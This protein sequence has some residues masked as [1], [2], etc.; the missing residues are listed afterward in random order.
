[1]S[2]ERPTDK[3]RAGTAVGV[4]DD[5]GTVVTGFMEAVKEWGKGLPGAIGDAS[6][7]AA[8]HLPVVKYSVEGTEFAIDTAQRGT[9]GGVV[10]TS[11]IAGGAAGAAAGAKVGAGFGSFLGPH[12]TFFG[13]VIGL[14]GGAAGGE[15]AA[16]A[17]AEWAYDQPRRAPPGYRP[18][19]P[20]RD[21]YH[22]VERGFISLR[23]YAEM[24]RDG[25]QWKFVRH[26]NRV[27]TGQN[28]HHPD[29][30]ETFDEKKYPIKW[31]GSQ[32]R[33]RQSQP[34]RPK[35]GPASP[36][37]RP[38]DPLQDPYHGV[39]RGFISLRQYAEMVRDGVQ[40]KFVRHVNRVITGQNMHH[41]DSPEIFDEK[42]Y[43]I[44]WAVVSYPRRRQSQ[45]R[46]PQQ[47]QGDS[48]TTE[49]MRREMEVI[50]QVTREREAA[51]RRQSGNPPIGSG[52]PHRE[53]AQ[54]REREA[55]QR[56]GQQAQREANERL[57]NFH[58]RRENQRHGDGS[59]PPIYE[60]QIPSWQRA[61]DRANRNNQES[62]SDQSDQSDQSGQ[63]GSAHREAAQ[64]RERAAAER[65]R[66]QGSGSAHREAAQERERRQ[67]QR[68]Q[69][70][71]NDGSSG[72][73][74]RNSASNRR[75]ITRNPFDTQRSRPPR[76]QPSSRQ[77]D[78]P[79][80][81]SGSPHSD[82]AQERERAAAERRRQ[83][84]SGSPHREA[85]QERERRQRQR[86]QGGGNEGN[87]GN[88]TVGGSSRSRGGGSSRS[89]SGGSSRSSSGGSSR[90]SSGGSSRSSSGGSS[91]SSSGGS[92]RSSSGGSSR[93]RGGGS[94][95]SRSGGSSSR[96]GSGSPHSDAARSRS[97]SRSS[98]GHRDRTSR[99]GGMGG[100]PIILDLDGDG[101]EIVP[102]FA[103]RAHI[104]FDEDGY[105]EQTAWVAPDDGLL[106]IDLAEDGTAG[107]DGKITS[108][109]EFVFTKWSSEAK[110]DLEALR[111]A[112]DS[113]NDGVLDNRDARFD[114][115][116]V[117][118][119]MNGDG[120]VDP[121]ELKTLTEAGIRSINLTSDNKRQVL[122]DGT[123]IFGQ[124]TYSKTDGTT[125]RAADVAFS[126]V[127]TGYRIVKTSEGFR[128]DMEGGDSRT[129]YLHK[130]NTPANINI[131]AL[132]RAAVGK[133]YL[134]AFGGAAND[135]IDARGKTGGI[136]LSGGAGSDTL[137]G[138]SGNDVLMGN[139][140]ADV[141][142][143]GA[144]ND[145]LFVDSS[146][147]LTPAN[148]D[149]GEGYDQLVL[150]GDFAV[151]L[152]VD[153][154][155]IESVVAR[156]GNDTITGAND[157]IN[158]AF[159]GGGG[160]DTLTGAAGADILEGGTGNDVLRGRA[161]NDYLSGGPGNDWLYGGAGNDII[162]GGAGNDLLN[163]GA[164]DD[165]Y[166]FN[167]GDG[168]DTI[169]DAG[170]RAAGATLAQG[171]DRIRLGRGIAVE[172]I[173]LKRDGND[174]VIYIR[175]PDSPNQ[176]LSQF[177][178]TL[179]IRNWASTSRRIE[180][181][182]FADGFHLKLSEFGNTVL[183][184]DLSAPGGANTPV[185]D[186]LMGTAAADWM[187]GGAGNDR[188]YGRAGND[189]LFG[190]AGDDTLNGGTGNDILVGDDGND[191][192]NGGA[193]NDI[194]S[195][196]VGRDTLNG[197][198]GNDTLI[199]G[200]GN[201][202]LYGGA[203]DDVYVFN[204][205]DGKDTID[206]AGSRAAGTT[207]AQGG[208]RIRLGRGITVEDIILKRDG[209]DLVI[210]I[211]DP[212][213]PN[214]PLSQFAN[215]LRIRNWASTSR[216]IEWLQFADGFHL[217][218]SEF[219]NTVLGVDLSAPGGANT[220]VID[221]L[222]GTAAA[223]W[224][225]GGAGNDRLYGRAGNDWLFG[226]A[227][228]DTLSGG[229]GNDDLSGGAG[230]DTLIGGDG[231]DILVGDDGNDTLNGGAGND[232]LSGDEGSDTLHG[233]AGNDIL[234]GGAGRD[235]LNGG[236]G[237]DIISGGAGNDTLNGGAGD[238]VYVFNRGDGEDTINDTGSRAAGDARQ[239]TTGDRILFGIGIS[240]EHIILGWD[241]NDLVIY[242]RDPQNPN[243]PLS[244]IAN[245][246][247]IKNWSD[248]ANC[249]EWLQFSDGSKVRLSGVNF[250][251]ITGAGS[252]QI[253]GSSSNDWLQTGA[254]KDQ[255][256]GSAGS[257]ILNGGPGPDIAI[258]LYSPSGVTVNLKLGTG[259]GGHAEGDRLVNIEHVFGSSHN[260]TLT[261]D[262]GANTLHGGAGAD[263]LDGGAGADWASYQLS[264]AGVTVDLAQGI[265]SGGDAE[266]DQLSNIENI[267]GSAYND[268]LIGDGNDNTLYGVAGNDTLHGGSG[269]DTMI[270][271]VGEDTYHFASG[272][273]QDTFQGSDA[274]GIKGTDKYLFDSGDFD[275]E[276][277]WFQKSGN[278]L[279]VKMLGSTDSI[280][281]K[282]WYDAQGNLNKH[283]R[284][285]EVDNTFLNASDVQRLVNA[286]AGFTPND[287][288][289]GMG[290]SHTQLPQAVQAAVNAVWKPP[291]TT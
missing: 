148:I 193:G 267:R 209:N 2:S 284:G 35:Q 150:D 283:I 102:K 24:V 291:A 237:N 25:V 97:R 52:S 140:G 105:F 202:N 160:N 44:N 27:I 198:A 178:N 100:V 176:P 171:G 281:F 143:G 109:K 238:D 28:M 246:I 132:E 251:F 81:R 250:I 179:R 257:D 195:G 263:R 139:S 121:G 166:V 79:R 76:S 85:A 161:G 71:G 13:G 151:N 83:Q 77:S 95:R 232:I 106:V 114:E 154:L 247:T 218:L 239:N 58:I 262:G 215:T 135:L 234:T 220:P 223:D 131:A 190:R 157:R 240:L 244:Q 230:A 15:K 74:G 274:A 236:A 103:S 155:N 123:V 162:I 282:D 224:M 51:E 254:G 185:I 258:Y 211:R 42:K 92:S 18:Q 197:D 116:R 226:R 104:D 113:N 59:N 278:N 249:I 91:R 146:D 127:G 275:K 54:E 259:S 115:F 174:L 93:S 194:L 147:I 219:G 1:M 149:G 144:G 38:L 191:T 67:R 21:P 16:E 3:S 120:D 72:N 26:V 17:I 47:Q 182:Q 56:R 280:T 165:V 187:D 242:I 108:L 264:S 158:Y 133:K 40:W 268:V 248:A 118:Q 245:R 269:N 130:G 189:W 192:L 19:D 156:G 168:K 22:G 110:T 98:S 138:G 205:G 46:P 256:Y 172:D 170:S 41:P 63:S 177:A 88:P 260:D 75:E 286:M 107:A 186:N 111:L 49:G 129:V 96:S 5:T 287:G 163:G 43:P 277:I 80:I 164:G 34:S 207:P 8:K 66:Q 65:R 169:D 134:A 23:Q 82:A 279:V 119:D 233:D 137:L 180:W 64:E 181:L 69:G 196:G 290:I 4:V 153:A 57:E 73:R 266:G 175:D 289:T 273:G 124:T 9:R 217:K 206:D 228:N 265:G 90:S 94:S 183:G 62:Q 101:V 125:G 252:S 261:G 30:P 12:G 20:L 210:Y 78:S 159:Y 86:N 48:T 285:F 50:R 203:G 231:N 53:A 270:A 212:D 253:S 55:A 37:Y 6:K 243:Q 200:V 227:G 229:T 45:P 136:A 122:P 204:R 126:Y 167:R 241:E 288:S 213:S 39:E 61:L 89:S 199:G 276:H 255:F 152:N 32:S 87:G 141:L 128:L 216:R 99:P 70:S 11:G 33:R 235:T 221:N 60:R 7:A 14:I 117:W 84:G 222:M 29:S 271:S 145:I 188:L 184:V 225:D 36:G 112:F 201:D 10:Q 31:A 272:D 208:D 68:N 173:I 142:K 214:Q